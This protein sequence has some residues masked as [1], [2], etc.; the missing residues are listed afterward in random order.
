MYMCCSELHTTSMEHTSTHHPRNSAHQTTAPFHA[1]CQELSS[2]LHTTAPFHALCQELYT[3]VY[4]ACTCVYELLAA[5]IHLRDRGGAPALPRSGA[6]VNYNYF[7]SLIESTYHFNAGSGS[8]MERPSKTGSATVAAEAHTAGAHAVQCGVIGFDQMERMWIC[9]S[10]F[11]NYYP[12]NS[13]LRS[14][15]DVGRPAAVFQCT[16][17]LLSI[18]LDFETRAPWP[19]PAMQTTRSNAA[20]SD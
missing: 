3:P 5:V 8:W 7:S 16:C 9:L 4:I 17:V 19:G 14:N 12:I 11:R 2:S 1:W 15:T 10:N 20:I 6:W 18:D 13:C